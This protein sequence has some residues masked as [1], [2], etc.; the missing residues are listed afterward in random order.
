MFSVLCDLSVFGEGLSCG[1]GIEI[2]MAL[3]IHRNS[4]EGE[5]HGRRD[6]LC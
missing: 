2:G 1:K 4:M 5:E 3:R 6:G